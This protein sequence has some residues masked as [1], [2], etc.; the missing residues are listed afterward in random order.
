MIIINTGNGGHNCDGVFG[1]YYFPFLSRHDDT[2]LS[3]VL[4][5]PDALLARVPIYIGVDLLS[6][7]SEAQGFF[8]SDL[9]GMDR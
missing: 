8:T 6:L 7:V 1:Y 3:T 2:R 4:W 5:T 9:N